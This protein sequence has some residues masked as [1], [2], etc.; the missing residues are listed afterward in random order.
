MKALLTGAKQKKKVRKRNKRKVKLRPNQVGQQP[1]KE[2]HPV[3][4]V[5]DRTIMAVDM[6]LILFFLLF[7][8]RS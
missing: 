1:V 2:L 6:T 4:R 8:H 7:I 5:Q 3:D